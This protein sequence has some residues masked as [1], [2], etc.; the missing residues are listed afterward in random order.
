MK[1]VSSTDALYWG[2]GGMRVE[3]GEKRAPKL[4][5]LKR[6]IKVQI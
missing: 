4:K 2:P 6:H 3:R 1:G 5:E